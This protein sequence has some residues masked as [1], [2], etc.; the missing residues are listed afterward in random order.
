MNVCCSRHGLEVQREVGPV[1]PSGIRFSRDGIPVL[2]DVNAVVGKNPA[3]Q[4]VV[5]LDASSE[6]G[7]YTVRWAVVH[8]IIKGLGVEPQRDCFA[9]E[10]NQRFSAYWTRED[11]AM[12]KVWS[13]GEVLWLNPPGVFGLRWPKRFLK[14]RVPQFAF[15]PRGQNPGCRS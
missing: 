9:A 10:G 12:T 2:A 11:D 7:D 14:A 4:S 5:D 8:E 13:D 15:S 3:P 1:W 6:L